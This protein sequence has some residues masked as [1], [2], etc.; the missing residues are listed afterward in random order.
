MDVAKRRRGRPVWFASRGSRRC[1]GGWCGPT[2][3][4]LEG[5]LEN[6]LLSHLEVLRRR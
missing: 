4:A 6:Q 5:S 2:Y 1:R 3:V